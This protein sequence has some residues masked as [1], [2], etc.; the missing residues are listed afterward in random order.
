MADSY[1]K[2]ISAKRA[3]NSGLALTPRRAKQIEV[4]N[5]DADRMEDAK[6]LIH[7]LAD[8]WELGE[9]LSYLADL[10]YKKTFEALVSGVRGNRYWTMDAGNDI[11]DTSEFALEWAKQ[12]LAN[13]NTDR[14]TAT[15]LRQLEQHVRL[16][17]I[18]GF[19]PTPKE[20]QDIMMLTLSVTD[21]AII[22]EP[23]AGAG[24][25][26]QGIKERFP[27]AMIDCC[28]VNYSLRNLLKLK[29]FRLVGDDMLVHEGEYDAIVMNPP[30]ER[31]MDMTM[32]RHAYDQLKAGGK[33]ISVLS[34]GVFSRQDNKSKQFREWLETV[35]GYSVKL[36]E[37]SFASSGTNVS[38]RV[39]F[40]EKLSIVSS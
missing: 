36:P 17:N 21:N 22:W 12:V 3:T 29:G 18:E 6:R 11:G 13:G 38:A 9:P 26:A 28:E 1:D 34:E 23:N 25:L 40:I 15:K 16:A 14:D 10:K 8:E 32:V 30:F 24:D 7:A 20:V 37:K 2:K 4:A 33:L 5:K 31:G 19:Y 39:V 27:T 35:N